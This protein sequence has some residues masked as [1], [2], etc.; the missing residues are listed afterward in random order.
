MKAGRKTTRRA[1]KSVKITKMVPLRPMPDTTKVQV[2][3]QVRRILARRLENKAVGWNVETC[4]SHNSAISSADCYPLVQQ[5]APGT[6]GTAQQRQGDR[7][8][9]KS[10]VVR[11]V[12][13]LDNEDMNTS[14]DIYVR[15]VIASQK[16]IK[17]GSAITGGVDASRLL[18]PAIAGSPEQP[19]N[20]NTQELTYPINKELFR[21][22]MDKTFKLTSA[23][24]QS[25]VVGFGSVEANAGYSRRWG[26]RFKSLPS[27]L[28]YDDGNG[29]W[30]NNFAPFVAIGYAFSD[31]TPPDTITTRI[32]SNTFS[33]LEY[34]DA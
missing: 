14:Q 4:V 23:Q 18:R 3:T 13:A 25:G 5:I 30:A 32:K 1:K 11:G 8:T 2:Q 10:L 28:T 33:L 34:E 15:V 24:V 6:G 21:V 9:P 19:F 31:C 16:N 26:Y 22:Y 7:I 17:V 27:A 29:D 20:G 12:V